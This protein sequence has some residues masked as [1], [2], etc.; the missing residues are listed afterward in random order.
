MKQYFFLKGLSV[1]ALAA[2]AVGVFGYVVMALWNWVVPAVTGWHTVTLL[3]AIG[4]LVLCRIL[5][6]GLRGHGGGG[7]WRHRIRWRWERMAP[8]ERERL[9]ATLGRGCR[10]DSAS[11]GPG[12]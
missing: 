7:H 12:A 4:L 2:L 5:F 3:Q 1:L 11:S 10:P 8:E 6:G 9:R